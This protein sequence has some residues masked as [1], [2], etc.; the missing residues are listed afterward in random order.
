MTAFEEICIVCGRTFLRGVYPQKRCEL[1]CKP[2]AYF[3]GMKTNDDH[4]CTFNDYINGKLVCSNC[5]KP[6]NKLE[7]SLK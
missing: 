7:D 1:C 2:K 6:K 3:K 4:I 5:G